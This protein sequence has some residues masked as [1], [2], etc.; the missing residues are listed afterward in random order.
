MTPDDLLDGLAVAEEQVASL[1]EDVARL[2]RVAVKGLRRMYLPHTHE[3]VQTLRGIATPTGPRL[4]PEG[5]NL[6]YA[7]MV[8]LGLDLTPEDTQKDVLA[9]DS[10]QSLTGYLVEQATTHP[11]P[12]AVALTAWAAAEVAGR[13]EPALFDRLRAWLA[14]PAPLPTV[15]V[16]WMLTAAIEAR[17][18]GDTAEVVDAARRRLLAEQG[19]QG[20][21]PHMLP[22]SSQGRFRAHVGSFADQVYPIQALARYAAATG[23]GSALRAANLG[24]AQICRLQ[25]EAGQWWWHYDARDGSVVEGFPVYSVHQHAMAPMILLDLAE[26]G[27]DDH[28]DA[29]E[30]GLR[31]LTVHP[32]VF[33]EL[34][35]EV[36]GVVWRK[37]G[38]REP[39]KAV[40]KLNAVSTS[41]RPGL[42]VP[43]VDRV[44]PAGVI[45]LECRPYELG[46]L[47]YAWLR[48]SAARILGSNVFDVVEG[49]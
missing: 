49:R 16:S 36:D 20:I 24:A 40:R 12:G 28:R 48:P 18:L 4:A 10:A 46:W 37:V 19:P 13:F 47:L 29:V 27:G 15:D 35:D 41:L 33:G 43:G 1:D 14:D 6:R 8:A 7:A 42:H 30:K 2:V 25:G 26:C 38:R 23:D 21:F 34:V 44:F 11:D 31:W 5:T 39:A 9:G 17:A 22:P 32:E 3:F 45:D